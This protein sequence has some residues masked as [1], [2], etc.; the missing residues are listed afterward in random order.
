MTLAAGSRVTG[1][2]AGILG[3]GI[4]SDSGT[5]TVDADALVRNNQ[6]STSQC[7]GVFIGNCPNPGSGACPA[8]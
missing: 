5:V 3:G 1:N 4:E 7:F 8:A 6:P 2:T